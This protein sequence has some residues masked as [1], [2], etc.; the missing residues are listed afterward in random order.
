MLGCVCQVDCLRDRSHARPPSFLTGAEC[1]AQP[2]TAHP[3]IDVHGEVPRPMQRWGVS[4]PSELALG[5][6]SACGPL[7]GRADGGAANRDM[8]FDVR[9]F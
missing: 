9:G 5:I 8:S 7:Q 1:S 3:R 4:A 2:A 6:G